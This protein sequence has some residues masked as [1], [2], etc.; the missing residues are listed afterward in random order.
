MLG[1]R[2][3]GK[4]VNSWKYSNCNDGIT[5][6]RFVFLERTLSIQP[7]PGQGGGRGSS[8]RHIYLTGLQ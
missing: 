6:G 3:I 4:D 7:F 8:E 5:R 1:E 2:H